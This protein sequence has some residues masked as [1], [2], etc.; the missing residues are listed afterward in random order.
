M[1]DQSQQ[2]SQDHVQLGFEYS[3]GRR[4]LNLSVC[5]IPVLDHPHSKRGYSLCLNGIFS[6]YS[7]SLVLSLLIEENLILSRLY[8]PIRYL[9]TL[10]R[11]PPS[12]LFSRLNS[13]SSHP[14]II[15]VTLW[16]TYSLMSMS[17]LYWGTQNWTQHSRTGFTSRGARSSPLTC[18]QCFF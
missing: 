3:I 13:Y 7:L 18:W 10:V 12:L 5:T 16:R 4:L 1:Q 9:Y 11:F 8:L 14:F 6:L 15:F 2:F 17:I